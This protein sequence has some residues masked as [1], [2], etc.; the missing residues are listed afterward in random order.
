[1][2]SSITL[3]RISLNYCGGNPQTN[4]DFILK[5]HISISIKKKYLC[6]SVTPFFCPF[7]CPS[8]CSSVYPSV[9]LS[10]VWS[11]VSYMKRSVWCGVLCNKCRAKNITETILLH[12]TLQR[13][14]GALVNSKSEGSRT[15]HPR[16]SVELMRMVLIPPIV[17]LQN[18]AYLI[19][20]F[21]LF[22]FL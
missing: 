8:I 5:Q 10:V 11:I 18:S 12:E 15:V 13:M 16:G 7:I 2:R 17:K 1:M 19:R 3:L 14:T 21:A 9:N 6:P 20:T 4:G 22:C